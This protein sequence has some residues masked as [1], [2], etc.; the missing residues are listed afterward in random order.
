[1]TTPIRRHVGKISNTDSRVVITMMQIPDRPTHALIVYADTMPGPME[2]AI[3]DIV[4]S[5][6]GQ[7]EE[8]L[9][10]VLN[11]RLMNNGKSVFLTMHE[12][13]LLHAVPIQQI[14]MM[15]LPHMPVP[16][17]TLLEQ[18]GRLPQPVKTE[19]ADMYTNPPMHPTMPNQHIQNV[20]AQSHE[21]KIDMARTLLMH[22]EDLEH[23][24]RKKR[25]E[26]YV[27]APSLRPQPMATP[28]MEM[29]ATPMVADPWGLEMA[30]PP[31]PKTKAPT[32]RPKAKAVGKPISVAKV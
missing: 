4:N 30:A 7:G 25:E 21:E 13:G 31:K 17:P 32:R 8:M 20:R 29:P 19:L 12:M 9:A 28:T 18:M 16:L 14:V 10:N 6:E 24:V 22:A 26:A 11:R 5:A 27:L 23:E 2:Q 1:M 15:P 3:N